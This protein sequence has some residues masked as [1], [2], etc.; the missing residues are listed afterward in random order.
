[1]SNRDIRNET[2]FISFFSID[3]LIMSLPTLAF[4]SMFPAHGLL[5]R[6]ISPSKYGKYLVIHGKPSWQ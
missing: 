4:S 6:M 2:D 3:I 5:P 1:M